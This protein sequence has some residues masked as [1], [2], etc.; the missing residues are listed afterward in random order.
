MISYSMLAIGV[1]SS[2]SSSR[3]L[4][5]SNRKKFNIPQSFFQSQSN[6]SYDPVCLSIRLSGCLFQMLSQIFTK[7]CN[8][9]SIR[10]CLFMVN[11]KKNHL[12]NELSLCSVMYGCGDVIVNQ[13]SDEIFIQQLGVV[14]TTMDGNNTSQRNSFWLQSW[15]IY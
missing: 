4:S 6:C 1:H 2:F 13:P 8:S 12:S 10:A 15:T 9:C 11:H 7:L 5:L 14:D 3:F